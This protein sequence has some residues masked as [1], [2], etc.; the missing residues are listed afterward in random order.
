M[1]KLSVSYSCVQLAFVGPVWYL[2]K[3]FLA[4]SVN[5]GKSVE[6]IMTQPYYYFRF[7]VVLGFSL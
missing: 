2:I 6:K 3:E 7:C 1:L 5:L 4:S